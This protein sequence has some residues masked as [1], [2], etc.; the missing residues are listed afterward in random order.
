MI[1]NTTHTYTYNTSK[2]YQLGYQ[3]QHT[4]LSIMISSGI[5]C[6]T[7]KDYKLWYQIQH[8]GLS[9][10]ISSGIKCNTSEDN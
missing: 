1:S 10:M 6:N 4:G 3:I 9:I 5:K 2:N 7:S 8:I